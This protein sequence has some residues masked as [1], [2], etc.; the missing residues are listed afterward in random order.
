MLPPSPISTLFPYTTLFRSYFDQTVFWMFLVP[1]DVAN[2]LTKP[3]RL[4]VIAVAIDRPIYLYTRGW[5]NISPSKIR[6][7]I[8]GDIRENVLVRNM[9]IKVKPYNPQGNLALRIKLKNGFQLFLL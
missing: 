4:T 1:C 7:M 8:L 2:T 5:L 9:T 3:A 6:C